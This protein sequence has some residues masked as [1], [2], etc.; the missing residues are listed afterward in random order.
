ME[1]KVKKL[2]VQSVECRVWIAKCRAG[3]ADDTDVDVADGDP[4]GG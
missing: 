1:R 3:S 4:G 2:R